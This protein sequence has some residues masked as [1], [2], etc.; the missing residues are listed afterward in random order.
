MTI[1][2]LKAYSKMNMKQYAEY[3]GIPYTTLQGWML[4][5]SNCPTYTLDLMEYKLKNENYK[6]K[7]EEIKA[8]C[9]D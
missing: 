6:K 5:K 8:L 4:N 2:E 9:G 1:Q 3:F 7:I